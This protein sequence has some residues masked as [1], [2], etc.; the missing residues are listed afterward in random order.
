MWV[1]KPVQPVVT[2]A[3][4]VPDS[5]VVSQ[6]EPGVNDSASTPANQVT[7]G[8]VSTEEHGWKLVTRKAREGTRV[9]VSQASSSNSFHLLEEGGTFVGHAEGGEGAVPCHS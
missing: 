2:S 1:P 8:P 6:E 5:P 4:S 3:P 7:V 9:P